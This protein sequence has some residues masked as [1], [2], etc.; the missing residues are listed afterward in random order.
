MCI[1]DSSGVVR[2]WY[3]G[4]RD[5]NGFL[6]LPTNYGAPNRQNDFREFLSRES[7]DADKKPRLLLDVRECAPPTDTPI[8]TTTPTITPTLT[9]PD[10]ATPTP[11]LATST[12][13]TPR[14]SPSPSVDPTP[15]GLPTAAFRHRVYLCLGW[16]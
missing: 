3:N 14:L 4:V 16:K 9:T 12:S 1:R 13:A 5:N 6:L 15:T 10:I 7:A 8:V 11:L 2:D